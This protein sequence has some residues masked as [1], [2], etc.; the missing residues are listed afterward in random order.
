MAANLAL[1]LLLFLFSL[2]HQMDETF[3]ASNYAIDGF[4]FYPIRFGCNASLEEGILGYF[5]KS[6]ENPAA[7]VGQQ[8]K[9]S[10]F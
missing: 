5:L 4:Y 8:G 7:F 3:S 10:S 2:W 6:P 1:W 9:S